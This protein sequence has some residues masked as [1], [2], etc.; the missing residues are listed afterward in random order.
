MLLVSLLALASFQTATQATTGAPP[1]GLTITVQKLP[2]KFQQ[3]P[4]V[5]LTFNGA[6]AVASCE[7][8][9]TSGSQGIDKVACAQA[10]SGYNV[11]AVKDK[12][13]DPADVTIAFEAEAPKN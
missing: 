9:K 11:E 13:P 5:H 3:N 7:L 8:V 10:V 6:G 4:V 1:V 2:A 12:V